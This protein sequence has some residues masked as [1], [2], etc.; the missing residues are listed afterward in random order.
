MK[1]ALVKQVLDT[2]GPWRSLAWGETS[3]A[4]ILRFWPGRALFWAMTVLL[5]ADWYV[6]PQ[7]TETWYTLMSGVGQAPDREILEKYTAGIRQ[8]G[9]IPWD[10]YDLVISLD[11][12]LRPARRSRAAR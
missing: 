6:L 2:H 5:E 4:D 8:P 10:A 1:V 9:D 11:P 7:Q 3:A 12:I